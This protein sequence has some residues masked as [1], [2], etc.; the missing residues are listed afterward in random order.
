MKKRTSEVTN[1][2]VA[3]TA[4]E[5]TR[6]DQDVPSDNNENSGSDPSFIGGYSKKKQQYIE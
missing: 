4:E 6:T 5:G 3:L 1:E 2:G